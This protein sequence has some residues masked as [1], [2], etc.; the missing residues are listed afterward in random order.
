MNELYFLAARGDFFASARRARRTAGADWSYRKSAAAAAH[1]GKACT[2]ICRVVCTL[3]D[4]GDAVWA[5]DDDKR[6]LPMRTISWQK[7]RR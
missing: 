4:S 2:N 1:H 5:D 7:K 3:L 6:G